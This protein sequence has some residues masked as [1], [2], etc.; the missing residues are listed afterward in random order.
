M[1]APT[2]VDVLIVG[3]GPAGTTMAIELIRR[4]VE[5]RIVDKEAGSFIGSRAKGVQPRT[6]EILEDLGALDSI[7]AGGALYP[8]MGIHIG[9]LTVPWAMIKTNGI[10]TA[11]PYPSTWL[12]PQYRT[13]RALHDRLTELGGYI[14]YNC[15]VQGFEQDE[16][17]ADVRITTPSGDET[18]K[19]RYVIGA[20]G[21][22][23]VIRK[24]A[25]IA[26]VGKT[27][28][29][30]RMLIL[31]AT[32]EGGLSR[33]HWHIWPIGGEFVGACP[34]PNT[35]QFQWMIKLD[36]GE[37]APTTTEAISARIQSRTKKKLRLTDITWQSV[38]RPNIR[39][40]E[41]YRKG[42]IFLVGDAAHVHPPAGAQGLNA[43]IQDSYNLAWKLGQVLAGASDVLLDTYE[44]ERQP[45]AATVLGLAT[46]KYDG[47]ATMSPTSLK[48]G[49]DEYQLAVT[50]N[51]GPLTARANAR[52]STL[53]VGDRAPDAH[54]TRAGRKTRLFEQFH[55]THFTAIAYGTAACGVLAK[56]DWPTA[57]ATLRTVAIN[58]S[59]TT[60]DVECSDVAHNFRNTYGLSGPAIILIRPDGYIAG[61]SLTD[62]VGPI[63]TALKSV[64]AMF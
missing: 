37:A 49:K 44:A 1:N 24:S 47:I 64:T 28:E 56:V 7:L 60:A 46:K 63:T 50:Y 19:A 31:D 27:D 17:S 4:G 20:D 5:V 33:S 51:G 6:L 8:K 11:V 55:G 12:I 34:L 2:K 42:R 13:D 15:Q 23:S 39:I 38:F 35:N 26:F 61:I 40:A 16:D 41:N 22:S 43:G 3:G 52:T 32:V 54:V 18:V 30:D 10:S 48:R 59:G 62:D 45:V 57:G 36:P 21:G 29:Q 14:D 53:E 9:P 58:A 25:G